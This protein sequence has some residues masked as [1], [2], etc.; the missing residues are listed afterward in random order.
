[1]EKGKGAIVVDGAV[2]PGFIDRREAADAIA[3]DPKLVA[4]GAVAAELQGEPRKGTF[5]ADHRFVRL[6]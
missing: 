1:M 6:R 4:K 3:A 5:S 2:Y